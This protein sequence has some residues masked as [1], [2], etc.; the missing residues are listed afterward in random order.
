MDND[1]YTDWQDGDLKVV[2]NHEE[3]FSIWPLDRDPPKGW[4]E[5]GVEGKKKECLDFVE[6]VWKDMRPLSLRVHMDGDECK[7]A[8]D[9]IR[10]ELERRETEGVDASKKEEAV[11]S[12]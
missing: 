5:V 11:E 1:E 4:A 6:K 8:W 3:Q 12:A 10:A 2:I 9:D 7:S